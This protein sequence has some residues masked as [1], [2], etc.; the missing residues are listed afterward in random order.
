MKKEIFELK[1][2]NVEISYKNRMEI[3]EGCSVDCED[4]E[5]IKLF[6][7]KEQALEEL[8]KYN[9]EIS[10]LS[11]SAG[12]YY[13]VTEYFVEQII[14]DDEEVFES[15]GIVGYS[16]IE[17]EVTEKPSY[18]TVGVYSNFVDAEDKLC[19]LDEGFLSFK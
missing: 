7:S 16:K 19:N 12:I 3:K 14:Y 6:E 18:E 1:K 10:E 13:N 17:I 5:I 2:S 9:T 4:P 15:I 11:G 8:K